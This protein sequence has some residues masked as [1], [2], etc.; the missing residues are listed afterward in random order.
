MNLIG[1]APH[2][3]V[4]ACTSSGWLINM[5]VLPS[6][7]IFMSIIINTNN[8]SLFGHF[9]YATFLEEEAGVEFPL[10]VIQILGALQKESVTYSLHLYAK[11][12]VCC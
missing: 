9:F 5:A 12:C 8:S 6:A 3:V 4:N 11:Y 7:T 1:V 2:H 10:D